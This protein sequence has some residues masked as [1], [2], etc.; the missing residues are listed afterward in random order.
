[1]AA[2]I[3][4]P[5]RFCNAAHRNATRQRYGLPTETVLF[6]YGF[7]LNS[8]AIR[9]NPMGALE[10]FQRAFPLPN[11]QATFGRECTFHPLSEHVSLLIK[12][13]PPRC[14]SA[15]WEWLHARAAEDPRIVLVT[16][17]LPRDELLSL[18]GCCDMSLSLHHSEGFER[19]EAET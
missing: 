1:M 18:Y 16:E 4:D 3:S 5:D 6:G 13:F 10:A 17:S 11:L 2:E 9:K 8:T 7:D 12:T 19:G 14:F 15:E